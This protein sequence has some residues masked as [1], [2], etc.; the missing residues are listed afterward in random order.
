MLLM[1]IREVLIKVN[2]DASFVE[3]F[4]KRSI[5]PCTGQFN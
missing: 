5:L 3:L 4:E 1:I 2:D